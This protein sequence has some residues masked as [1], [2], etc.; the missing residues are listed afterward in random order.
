MWR[1][2]NNLLMYGA[3][4]AYLWKCLFLLQLRSY[5]DQPKKIEYSFRVNAR[6]GMI[7]TRLNY[8]KGVCHLPLELAGRMG[9]SANTPLCNRPSETRPGEFFPSPSENL[10][11]PVAEEIFNFTRPVCGFSGATFTNPA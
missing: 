3:T 4:K 10:A 11:S 2:L 6:V 7:L 5:L 8:T 9:H 1:A